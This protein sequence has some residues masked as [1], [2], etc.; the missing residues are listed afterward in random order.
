MAW[1]AIRHA[2]YPPCQG[3]PS[4]APR[5]SL[6]GSGSPSRRELQRHRVDA[7]AQAGGRRAVGEDV[8]LV[9]AAAGAEDLGAHHA[10]AG[11][12]LFTQVIRRRRAR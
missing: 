9:A 4:G 10:V 5:P 8:A 2:A 3:S 1:S 12:A 7:V 11:V 6:S